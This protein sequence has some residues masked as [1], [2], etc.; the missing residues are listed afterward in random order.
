MDRRLGTADTTN[1]KKETKYDPLGN[2]DEYRLQV[3]R[4]MEKPY[5]DNGGFYGLGCLREAGL[6]KSR[7]TGDFRTKSE[8][9]NKEETFRQPLKGHETVLD[10]GL[11]IRSSGGSRKPSAAADDVLNRGGNWEPNNAKQT[12]ESNLAII[13]SV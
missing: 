10:R 13:R 2:F 7:H 5:P 6:R 8:F 4:T 3:Q 9:I 12:S 1:T 11:T